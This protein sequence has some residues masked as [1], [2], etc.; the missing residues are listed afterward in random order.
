MQEYNIADPTKCL[1]SA[2]SILFLLLGSQD[3]LKH[4][5]HCDVG[6]VQQRYL[7][8]NLS[9]TAAKALGAELRATRDD[10]NR[11]VFYCMITDAWLTSKDKPSVRQYFPGHVFII[12]RCGHTFSLFQSY[13]KQYDLDKYLA[14]S[15][16]NDEQWLHDI[17]SGIEMLFTKSVWDQACTDFWRRFT[18]ADSKSF[19]GFDIQGKILFCYQS[20]PLADCIGSLQ[21]IVAKQLQSLK[22]QPENGSFHGQLSNLDMLR[23]LRSMLAAMQ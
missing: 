6:A 8:E 4:T 21:H 5:R 14:Q 18:L 13:I 19:E 17:A 10:S 3:A 20:I 11:I 1:N 12:E 7:K 22:T 2:V 9:L 16:A 23:H 15:H